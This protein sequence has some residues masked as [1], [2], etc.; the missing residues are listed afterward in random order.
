MPKAKL[1]EFKPPPRPS[2]INE[3]LHQRIPELMKEFDAAPWDF[4]IFSPLTLEDG[5]IISVY[6]HIG[7]KGCITTYVVGIDLSNSMVHSIQRLP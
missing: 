3:L 5:I 6:L 4:K 2:N 7:E 1:L